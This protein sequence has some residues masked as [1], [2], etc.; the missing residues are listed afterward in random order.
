[1]PPRHVRVA[2]E[3]AALLPAPLRRTII[4]TLRHLPGLA[5]YAPIFDFEHPVELMIRWHGFTRLEIE[6]LCG[7]QVSLDHTHFFQ[8]FAR[9]P[10]SAHFERS[11]AL[12][13]AM[14]GDRLHQAA[15]S[16]ACLSATHS[17]TNPWTVSSAACRPII[18][19]GRPNRNASC[20]PCWRAMFRD[21][22]WDVPKH[23]FDFP[24]MDFLSAEDFQLVRRYLLHGDWA[25]WQVLSP[26]LRGRVWPPFHR[27]R[28]N[29]KLQGLGAGGAGR[30][31]GRTF[32][33]RIGC[34]AGIFGL[35]FDKI[36]ISALILLQKS[37]WHGTPASNPILSFYPIG[38]N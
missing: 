26:E 37:E 15:P 9:F 3:Y 27:R 20:V 21:S 1:M 6:A 31:A 16:P 2:V 12:L 24:L 5:G 36:T 19:T 7:E 28:T 10:R 13:D 17:G 32:R 29:A 8:T 22:L 33:L 18:V 30:L 11:I 23:S 14:P 4:A 34:G 35:R 25:Q 38:Q